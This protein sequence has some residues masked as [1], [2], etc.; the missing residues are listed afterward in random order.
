M[1]QD[2]NQW[3]AGSIADLT[4]SVTNLADKDEAEGNLAAFQVRAHLTS[5]ARGCVNDDGSLTPGPLWVCDG[6]TLQAELERREQSLEALQERV[7][8]L[9]QRAKLQEAPLQMQVIRMLSCHTPSVWW[10]PCVLL[11]L[12][13]RD[14]LNT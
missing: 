2:I 8:E 5:Y 3:S 6:T 7:A 1:E 4:D 14:E 13:C 10:K 11:L 12:R 9:K